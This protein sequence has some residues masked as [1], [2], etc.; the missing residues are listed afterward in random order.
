MCICNFFSSQYFSDMTISVFGAFIGIGGALWIFNQTLE[1][2]READENKKNNYLKNRLM[3]TSNLLDSVLIQMSRQID[4]F[5]DQ[6]ERI[7]DNPFEIHV[8]QIFAS[9]QMDRLLNIDSQDLF[10][11]FLLK[12]G[13][14]ESTIKKYKEFLGHIDFVAKSSTGIFDSNEKNV[15]NIG[16]DHENVRKAINLF[17]DRY[18]LIADD[19][20]TNIHIKSIMYK[21]WPLFQTYIGTGKVDLKDLNDKF[22]VKLFLEVR[23][24]SINLRINSNH[25]LSAIRDSTT[26]LHHIQ[27]NNMYYA[28][29]D[30]LKLKHRLADSIAYLQLLL[31]EL[32]TI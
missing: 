23:K 11:A 19:K 24:E 8:V 2:N 31:V 3:F 7:F 22:L 6:A 16:E 9:N 20:T 5:M 18:L 32:K 27:G 28:S 10:E 29:N 1:K 12:Y 26:L 17:Y 21:Y 13:N 14:N 15:F 4:M 25:I 30:A